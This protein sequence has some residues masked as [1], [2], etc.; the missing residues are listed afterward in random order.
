[1]EVLLRQIKT[2]LWEHGLISYD[3]LRLALRQA[4]ALLCSVKS[5][6]G[7]IVD[8]LVGIP[9]TLFTKQSIKLGVSF[10]M[11]VINEN[12]RMESRIMAEV[13]ENWEI[14]IRRAIGMFDHR[15]Q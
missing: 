6:D 13:V 12:P 10:W 3:E 5:D 1:M 4:A 14:T 8:Y 15:L 7:N 11:S 9:F 2:K